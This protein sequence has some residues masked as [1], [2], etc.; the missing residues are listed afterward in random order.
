M[1]RLT[2][3][4][5]RWIGNACIT[6]RWCLLLLPSA[7]RQ[8]TIYGVNYRLLLV[9]HVAAAL[10]LCMADHNSSDAQL[11]WMPSGS[12]PVDLVDC[13]RW[14]RQRVGD[15]RSVCEFTR[16]SPYHSRINYQAFNGDTHQRGGRYALPRPTH[17]RRLLADHQQP[18][19]SNADN[20]N[21]SDDALTMPM[22]IIAPTRFSSPSIA[23]QLLS[24]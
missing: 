11:R 18:A 23:I 6:V 2:I 21:S 24:S 19:C 15:Q 3:R 4:R 13:R 12:Q 14:R 1:H 9:G 17:C 16:A 10:P 5:R 7:T 20:Q 8:P 22:S